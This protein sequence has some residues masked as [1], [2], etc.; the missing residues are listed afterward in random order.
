MSGIRA[1]ADY[2]THPHLKC[3]PIEEQRRYVLTHVLCALKQLNPNSAHRLTFGRAL[4]IHTNST[5]LFGL[6]STTIVVSNFDQYNQ[7]DIT[8]NW[9]Y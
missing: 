9:R 7:K 6:T 3:M 8:L 4:I 2:R 5:P 1:Y